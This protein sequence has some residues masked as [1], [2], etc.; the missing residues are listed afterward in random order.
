M[1]K[2]LV[3]MA[4][5]VLL[6]LTSLAFAA[7]PDYAGKKILH[8]ASYHVGYAWTDGVNQS[9]EAVLK[10]K[11]IDYKVFY[12][13]AKR[14]P[15]EEWKK[16][17]ALKAK[18][19]IEEFKPDVVI[20]SDDD[21]AKYLIVPYYKDVDLPFVFCGLNWDA[22]TYGFPYKNVTGM[23]EVELIS[24]IEYLKNY[25]KGNRIG[26]L[27]FDGLVE[28]K[29]VQDYTDILKVSINQSYFAKTFDE[30][31]KSFLK[32]QT[33]VDMMMMFNYR[34]ISDWDTQVATDFVEQN[35]RIPI[36]T[37]L[38]WMMP[39]AMLALVRLP[40]EQGT[41]AAQTALKILD[42]TKPTDIPITQNKDAKLFI[43]MRIADKLGITFSKAF[44]KTA[45]IIR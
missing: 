9:I 1:L 21:A 44:L 16:A 31:K 12:M 22:S 10:D 4:I 25:A 35:V 11:G 26:T 14:N 38:S 13:D 39:V 30:W 5:F 33:E 18:T 37:G 8:I 34:G 20:T 36:S 3:K 2:N 24:M 19:L 40:E 45:E 28:R 27:A 41:W 7:S 23:L 17:E 42:G 32:L 6:S 15:A 43:N 29:V